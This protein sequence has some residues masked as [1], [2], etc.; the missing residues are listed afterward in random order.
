M[1]IHLKLNPEISD[2]QEAKRALTHFIEKINQER[3]INDRIKLV[4]RHTAILTNLVNNFNAGQKNIKTFK[5]TLLK[6]FEDVIKTDATKEYEERRAVIHKN[7]EEIKN[8]KTEK[9]A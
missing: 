8:Y 3:L 6:L 1:P 9:T 7:I 5:N 4:E 2:Y